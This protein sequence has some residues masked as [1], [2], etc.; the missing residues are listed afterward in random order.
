VRQRTSP[1]DERLCLDSWSV[2]AWLLGEEPSLSIVRKALAERRA[3]MSWINL[4]EVAYIVEWRFN[5][6]DSGAVVAQLMAD[7]TVELP[8]VATVLR[9]SS[10][11]AGNRVSYAD[12]FAIATAELHGVPLVTGDPEILE[13]P[14]LV[15]VVDARPSMRPS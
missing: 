10:L 13:L 6:E 11:K 8:T 4:G 14:D 9:A 12:A 2:I 7:A 3:V 1:A 15:R 5:T